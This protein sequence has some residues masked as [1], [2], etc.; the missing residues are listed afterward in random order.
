[1]GVKYERESERNP[2]GGREDGGGFGGDG[3]R[4]RWTQPGRVVVGCCAV[5]PGT[6]TLPTCRKMRLIGARGY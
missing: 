4:V 6:C 3:D 1:M 5:L 2:V